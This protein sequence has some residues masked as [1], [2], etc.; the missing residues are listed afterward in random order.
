MEQVH[1]VI[2]EL[3]G[4]V[5][6]FQRFPLL[7]KP[8]EAEKNY[9]A[10]KSQTTLTAAQIVSANGAGTLAASAAAAAA[11]AASAAAARAPLLDES[12]AP[13]ESQKVYVGG[14]SPTVTQEHLFALFCPFG[15]LQKVVVQMDAAT[16]ISKGFAFLSFRDP[17]EA[18]LAIQAMANQNLAGRPMKT[19]WANQ[20]PTHAGVKIVTSQEFP[21]DGTA[22]TQRAYQVLA[23]LNLGLPVLALPVPHALSTFPG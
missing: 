14:L 7:I 17:R 16:G 23:Q 21:P 19:G 15:Q 12:G 13:I 1:A 3:S 2:G 11:A 22:R 9:V 5:P 18:N 8:S 10:S 20:V 6:D 4:Q